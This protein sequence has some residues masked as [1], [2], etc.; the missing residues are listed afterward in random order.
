MSTKILFYLPRDQHGYP[1]VEVESLW[2]VAGEKGFELDNIPFYVKG[3]ARGDIVEAAPDI[4]G[5][6]VYER[7][8]KRGGHSTYRV[9]LLK[10]GPHDPLRTVEYLRS[11]GFGVEYDLPQL[12]AIDIPPS[13]DLEQA[14]LLLFDGVE[15]GVWELQEGY[16]A[17]DP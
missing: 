10:P 7:V 8:I 13:V 3:V 6:L 4:D 1:P 5:A 11:K 9:Y 12:L 14:E 2:A 15:G 17:G 16:R